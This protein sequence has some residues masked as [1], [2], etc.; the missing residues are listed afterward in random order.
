MLI[1]GMFGHVLRPEL[2]I[3]GSKGGKWML[4][5]QNVQGWRPD[6]EIRVELGKNCGDVMEIRA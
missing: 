3:R 2:E 1:A 6:V 4:F 5:V